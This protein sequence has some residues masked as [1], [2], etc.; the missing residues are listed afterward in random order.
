MPQTVDERGDD[1]EIAR[2]RA[3]IRES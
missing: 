2:F 3:M 1:Y